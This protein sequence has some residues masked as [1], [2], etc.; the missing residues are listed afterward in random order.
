MVNG[1]CAKVSGEADCDDEK[2]S[3]IASGRGS[4]GAKRGAIE[5]ASG[6]A[7]EMTNKKAS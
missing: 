1:T 6:R 5:G 2:A 7:G 4:G 3:G